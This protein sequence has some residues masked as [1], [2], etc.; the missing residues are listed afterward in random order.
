M[1][2]SG[3]KRGKEMPVLVAIKSQSKPTAWLPPALIFPTQLHGR[4]MG[5]PRT[6]QISYSWNSVNCRTISASFSWED[7]SFLH[8][9]DLLPTGMRIGFLNSYTYQ[10]PVLPPYL[11][12]GPTT[13]M[14]A[15][16]DNGLGPPGDRPMDGGRASPEGHRGEALDSL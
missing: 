5:V 12:S 16:M 9:F 8:P 14:N 13:C 2:R 3:T 10:S 11:A 15:V 6:L 7:S 1:L 4:S